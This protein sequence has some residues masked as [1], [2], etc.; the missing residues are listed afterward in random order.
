MR[1]G[2]LGTGMVGRAL[3]EGFTR[4]G[5]EVSMGTRDVHTTKVRQLDGPQGSMADWFSQNPSVAL[6]DFASV[7]GSAEVV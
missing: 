2:I 7:A 1:I 5:N 6:S 4:T 3:A